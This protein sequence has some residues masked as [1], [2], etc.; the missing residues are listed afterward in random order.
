ML[1]EKQREQRKSGLGGSDAATILG[2]NPWKTRYELYQEKAEG[3]EFESDKEE[4]DDVPSTWGNLLEEVI[5]KR[6]QEKTG[7]ELYEVDTLYHK[8]HKFMLANPDR[9][10]RDLGDGVRR[11]LEIKNVGW[12]AALKWGDA[13]TKLV[14]ENIYPQVAHYMAVADYD[15]WH[16]AAL[17][18]GNDFRTYTFER[19]MEFEEILLEEEH[20]FWANHVLK[21]NPPEVE[22][23]TKGM[24]LIKK[25][26]DK[27]EFNRVELPE[28]MLHWKD[29]YLESKELATK[30]KKAS[31]M[32]KTHI[33]EA[34]QNNEMGVLPDGSSFIRKV[35][36]IKG[37]TVEPR[38]DI[39]LDYK[40]LK[41]DKNV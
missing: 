28:S 4:D 10:I 24:E 1:T 14:P 32:A 34:L 6:Y 16:I 22:Y 21:K 41:V 7:H 23:S 35:R 33:L 37:F 30:Y 19:D 3:I 2:L 18:G 27:I 25:K 17:I 39:I 9:L 26:Y 40:A 8:T 38:Q 15:E 5:A 29:V 12:R 36:N 31:D 11:G 20:K 13:G